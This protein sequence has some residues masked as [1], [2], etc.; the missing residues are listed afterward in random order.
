MKRIR[1]NEM[2]MALESFAA[3]SRKGL[4]SGQVEIGQRL[5]GDWHDNNFHFQMSQ[6]DN[7]V[8]VCIAGREQVGPIVE[9]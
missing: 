7:S 6:P 2:A 4:P 5:H 3:L 9:G 8:R 1:Y